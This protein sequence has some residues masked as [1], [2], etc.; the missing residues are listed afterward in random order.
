VSNKG[1][2]SGAFFCMVG[3]AS[4]APADVQTGQQLYSQ[5]AI[6]H[7]IGDGAINTIGPE[8][9]K[10][11]GRKAGVHPDYRFSDS[12]IGAGADGLVWD[13]ATLDRFLENPR[14]LI[15]GT[16]MN[17]RGMRDDDD[18]AAL[19]A[20]LASF[21]GENRDAPAAA[22]TF[23]VAPEILAIAGDAAY[24]EYLSGECTACHN[25][26]DADD[27]IPSISGHSPEYFVTVMQA[28]KQ[29]AREHPVM[30]MLAR[31]LSNEEIAGLA[32]YF[33]TVD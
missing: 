33:E 6:C 22:E 11:I 25:S 13:E 30:S 9:T 27:G 4:A 32:A 15:P 3:A 17:Y 2:L 28:Y 26:S 19:I 18:R 8:L 1:F 5:C 16:K 31:R 20:Y 12:L 24:G 21:G 14:D 29:G 23:E 10:I 7:Q